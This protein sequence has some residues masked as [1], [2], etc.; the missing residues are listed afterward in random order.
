MKSN[1]HIHFV[2]GRLAETAVRTVVAE[3]AEKRKFRWSL[4]VLPISVAA[5]MTARWLLRH[6]EVPPEATRMILPG[7]LEGE[8]QRIQQAV[9]IPVL[10][11]PKNILDLPETFGLQTQRAAEYGG[12]DIEIIAEINHA[13]RLSIGQLTQIAENL[14]SDGADIIDLGCTPDQP[15][16]EVG[17]AVRELKELGLRISIDSFDPVEVAAACSAGAEL[18]LSVNSQNCHFAADWAAEVVVI[19]DTPEDFSSLQ[20]TAERLEHARVPY[21]LDPILAPI[22]LGFAESLVRYARCREHFPNAPMMMGIGN[23]TEL[24][25][26]DS[27]GINTLLLGFCQELSI[28][29]VLTT[30]VINWARSSVRECDLARRLVYHARSRGVPPKHLEPELVLLR[31]PRVREFTQQS[32]AEIGAGIKDHNFRLFAAG[33]KIHAVCRGLH[34]IGDDPFE[35]MQQV[36]DSPV[37]NTIDASHAFYLGFEMCKAL[38]AITLGKKYEQD[39]SLDW[40]FLTREERH[41]RL[42]SRRKTDGHQKG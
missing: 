30:Q 7:Y 16:R 36:M 8:L 6:L 10:C 34:A 11:G 39:E 25:D 42:T 38:Q 12:Y 41:W 21:R 17:Q 32:I 27:A 26:A 40:G 28:R 23:L 13:N 20:Q 22:G 29:S 14:V 1:E 24:T 37:G 4:Q 35:V 2:T 3:L 33:G 9:S 19:P 15:W 18:V 5:L 31:D